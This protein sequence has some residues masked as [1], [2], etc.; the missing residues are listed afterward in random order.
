MGYL[1]ELGDLTALG[2]LKAIRFQ[3]VCLCVSEGCLANLGE[4][5]GTLALLTYVPTFH[6]FFRSILQDDSC[7]H[8]TLSH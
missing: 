6:P 1:E 7:C 5:D 8:E 3:C 2:D 4:H